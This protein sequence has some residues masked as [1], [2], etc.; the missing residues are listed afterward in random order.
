MRTYSP[1]ITLKTWAFGSPLIGRSYQSDTLNGYRFGFNGK[2]GDN[3]INVDG[4]SYD[5]GA[6]VYDSRLGRWLS[7]DPL[8]RKYP[9]L[10]PYNYCANNPIMF[11]DPDGK[12]IKVPNVADREAVLKMINSR[13]RGVFI[14]D[15]NGVLSVKTENGKKGYSKEYKDDLIAGI[16]DNNTI[17][18]KIATTFQ[19]P[20][21][22]EKADGTKIDSE[23]SETRNVNGG[24][25]VPTQRVFNDH[26]DIDQSVYIDG[27]DYNKEKS[28]YINT[29]LKDVD[30]ELLKY[31][32]ADI[33]MHELVGHAIPN[34]LN[35]KVDP[36]K[37]ENKVR[38]QLKPGS[39][40]LRAADSKHESCMKC[41]D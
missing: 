20:L 26:I 7:L 4:G 8:Q 9:T 32:A 1:N 22:Y 13:A 39:N 36:I 10:S 17:T 25:T 15:E 31:D 16:N 38:E 34:A 35:Q 41:P 23:E 19:S 40:K 24:T 27:K 18:I 29:N 11:I 30:G 28:P 37:E 33:L 12:I 21:F 6:R 14:F 2:E 5:F 3:E